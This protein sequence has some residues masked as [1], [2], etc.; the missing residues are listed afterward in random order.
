MQNY[1]RGGWR[2]CHQHGAAARA[3]AIRPYRGSVH[4]IADCGF[5]TAGKTLFS[6][7]GETLRVEAI[8]I[9]WG[10]ISEA[11]RNQFAPSGGK[12]ID[13][14]CVRRVA[15]VGAHCMRPRG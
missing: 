4:I 13:I 11:L 9:S 15:S 10:A 14:S 5:A 7:H 12:I 1:M 8:F 3:Y 6:P 2:S